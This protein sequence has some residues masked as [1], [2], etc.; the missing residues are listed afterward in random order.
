M[1]V[2]GLMPSEWFH[3]TL[4]KAN[5]LRSR[6]ALEVVAMLVVEGDGDA[7]ILEPHCEF[8]SQQVM[9]VEGRDNVEGVIRE[10]RRQAPEGLEL[11][12]LTDCDGLGKTP[13][14]AADRALIVTQGCD[15][16]ADLFLLGAVERALEKFGVQNA[17]ELSSRA[18]DMAVP[19]SALRRGAHSSR[20]GMKIGMPGRHPQ[21]LP[22]SKLGDEVM[23]TCAESSFDEALKAVG[24]ACAKALGW[25]D[26]VL[27]VVLSASPCGD[28]ATFAAVGSGKDAFDGLAYLTR[29]ISG[30]KEIRPGK[31]VEHCERQV[32]AL[33]LPEWHVGRRIMNWQSAAGVELL[34]AA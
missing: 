23:A 14:L 34:K 21:R 11:V 16:E 29:E 33:D 9:P 17:G 3:D 1:T 5:R 6:H 22:F 25:D 26:E 19:M 12:G 4:L 31:F 7:R 10:F 32:G 27:Q 15:A 20:V 13:D 28:E 8:G 18:V 2:L 30:L 24:R